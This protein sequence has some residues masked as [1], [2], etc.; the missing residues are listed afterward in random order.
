M[1]S[2]SAPAPSPGLRLN[3]VFSTFL[4]ACVLCA[5]AIQSELASYVQHEVGYRKPYFLFWMTHSGYLLLTPL[6]L[7]TL[8][9]LRVPLAPLG[10]ELLAVLRAKYS[11]SITSLP[12][13]LRQRRRE[14]SCASISS[15]ASLASLDG[16]RELVDEAKEEPWVRELAK[17]VAILTVAIAAPALSWY[18]AVPLTSMTDITALYNSFAFWAYL[19][20]LFYLPPPSSPS[21]P[22]A[23]TS[24]WAR[25]K[26]LDALSVL[27]AICGVFIIAYGDAAASDKKEEEEAA[28]VGRLVGNALAL[29]GS[30]S[31]AAYEVWYKKHTGLIEVEDRRNAQIALPSPS[32]SGDE[33]LRPVSRATSRLSTSGDD[34]AQEEQPEEHDRE[35]SS[36]LSSPSSTPS[37]LP[38]PAPSAAPSPSPHVFLLYS[39]LLTSLI[40]LAT[41]LCLWIPLPLLHWTGVEAF[42]L[43][44]R[45][46]WAA[47]AGIVAGGVVFNGG[48]M[49]MLA[50]WGPVISSIANLLTL[51][52][53]ALADYLFVSSAPPLTASTLLGGAMIVGAFGGVIV[54]E[55][56]ERRGEKGEGGN[57]GGV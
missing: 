17:R 1:T 38:S 8:A 35:T 28:G 33:P 41:L 3:A 43:P 12:A 25:L 50:V 51:L 57:G 7:L 4:L 14:P 6:H 11:P 27:L 56:R 44:P 46:S 54:G 24:P 42:Q 53:V 37:P 13:W 34:D 15:L 16:L 23:P 45:E 2:S 52:L 48:F 32:S 19:L 26:P 30:V 55:V 29:F 9:V 5:Y 10:K 49:V 22:T 21:K 36:L 47:L 18:A 39:T 31:Y 20:T 40:G